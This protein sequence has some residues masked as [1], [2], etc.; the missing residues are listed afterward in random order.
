M[1]HQELHE[2]YQLRHEENEGE[3]NQSEAGMTENFADDI[4]VKNAHG[5]IGECSTPDAARREPAAR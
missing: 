3:D 5:A 1:A 2:P 4:A